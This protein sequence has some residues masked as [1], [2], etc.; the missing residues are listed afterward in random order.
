M[1][2]R[3]R[4]PSGRGMFAALAPSTVS[5]LVQV[6]AERVY[7]PG[8]VVVRE[9]ES[10]T[11]VVLLL[12]G[13][14]KVTATTADGGRALLAVRG[15]GELVGELAGLDGQPRSATVTAVGR[16]RTRVI[17]RA[18]FQRFLIRHPDAAMAVSRMVAAKLRWSTQR[19]IDFSG[20]D[21]PARLARILVSLVSAY[22]ALT[23]R[24]WEIGFPITQPELAALIGAAEPTV[25]KSLTELRHRKVLDTGYRRM[26]ILDLPAL[27]LAAGLTS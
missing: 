10:T 12:E 22:G 4:L 2:V 8:D 7:R 6:G 13:C 19:R 27:R 1:V 21:V 25:H 26:T 5:S 24:G 3:D 16:L 20:Y 18:E 23:S 15:G 17:G 11:F 14:V 9:G